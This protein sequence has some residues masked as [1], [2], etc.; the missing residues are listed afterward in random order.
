MGKH[1]KFVRLGNKG[2]KLIKQRVPSRL[3]LTTLIKKL[4]IKLI[5]KGFFK[6]QP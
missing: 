2:E 4:L 5:D 3:M 1:F 6:T